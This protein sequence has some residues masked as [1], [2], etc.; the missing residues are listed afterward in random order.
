MISY[1]RMVYSGMHPYGTVGGG[2]ASKIFAMKSHKEI[3]F[4]ETQ[5]SES[6][7]NGVVQTMKTTLR[8]DPR[9]RAN[10]SEL[11]TMDFL[12]GPLFEKF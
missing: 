8:K 4:P 10:A 12:A 2:K 5:F 3:D 7:S 6:V 11:L 9:E 1:F